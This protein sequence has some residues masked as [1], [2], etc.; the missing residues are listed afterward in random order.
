MKTSRRH[1]RPS[2]LGPLLMA[3]LLG[4]TFCTRL[5]SPASGPVARSAL[6][7]GIASWYGPGFQGRATSNREVY[8][9]NEMTAAHRT[10]PF[11]TK[12]LVTNLENGRQVRVRIN[13]RGPFVDDRIIDLSLAAARG[14]DM[15]GPGTVRVRLEILEA[16]PAGSAPH[17]YVQAGAFTV[18]A[19][20]QAL[21]A[22]L[23]SDYPSLRVMR[24]PA[25]GGVYYRVRIPGSGRNEADRIAAAL[26]A[27]GFSA[28]VL[29]RDGSGR[30]GEIRP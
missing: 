27:R 3:S 9:M 20:A 24:T 21:A 29:E 26:A 2:G 28:L 5:P 15:V 16:P 8:D 1:V 11:N 6:E 25:D 30:D 7:T 23:K 4:L 17:Y 22:Q 13:D 12:V 10:L 19:N 18:E 14:L